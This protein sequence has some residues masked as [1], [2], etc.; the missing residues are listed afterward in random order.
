[1]EF[2]L[3]Q[4]TDSDFGLLYQI[5]VVSIKPY[6]EQIWGWDEQVQIDFLKRETPISQVKL[7]LVEKDH[8]AGFCPI[9]RK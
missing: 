3:R 5:K 1:M 2:W 4:A 8:V 7:I 9:N 6:V